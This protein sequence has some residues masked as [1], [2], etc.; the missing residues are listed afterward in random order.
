MYI[1]ADLQ[2]DFGWLGIEDMFF[3]HSSKLEEF[4]KL[5]SDQEEVFS[6]PKN[7]TE[8]IERIYNAVANKTAI[9][10]L[11]GAVNER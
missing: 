10:E 7:I 8:Q 9:V 5:Y 3:V 2:E 11:G 4:K 1:I 6:V